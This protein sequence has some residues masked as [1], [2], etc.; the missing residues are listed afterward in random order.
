VEPG[1]VY[2]RLVEARWADENESGGRHHIFIT[3][4]DENGNRIIGQPVVV[5]WAD[6]Q[7]VRPTEDKPAN[8]PSFN[9]Q[10]YA[11][12]NAYTAYV[13]GLPSDSVAGM[14]LG[15]IAQRTWKHHTSF[16][17]VFQRAIR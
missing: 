8:E 4:L 11:A 13:D 14:G 17:L 7:E 9:F 16:Y 1:Q 12:G 10:M 5:R 6:G 3:V 2:W 15:T